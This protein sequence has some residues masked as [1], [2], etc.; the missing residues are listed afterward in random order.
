MTPWVGG[1]YHFTKMSGVESASS[2]NNEYHMTSSWTVYIPC[3]IVNTV[4]VMSKCFVF[5][6]TWVQIQHS[7]KVYDAC[8]HLFCTWPI[9]ILI[10]LKLA[11]FLA[12]PGLALYFC[13]YRCSWPFDYIIF[14]TMYHEPIKLLVGKWIKYQYV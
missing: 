6:I 8:L 10:I 7:M 9:Y 2:P 5:Q 11:R 3:I 1:L 14:I 13:L 4:C 12:W